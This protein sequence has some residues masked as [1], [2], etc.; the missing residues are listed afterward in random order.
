MT[1]DR[2]A[3][4][5]FAAGRTLRIAALILIVAPLVLLAV[6]SFLIWIPP[7]LIWTGVLYVIVWTT[8]FPRGRR[9]LFVTSNSPVWQP[10]LET[11]LLPHIR[12]RAVLLNWSE[13]KRWAICSF[14][15]VLF[16]HFAGPHQFNPAAIVFDAF[17]RARVFRFY[18]PFRDFKHGHPQGVE[19]LS[20]ELLLLL[21]ISTNATDSPHSN[22][23]Q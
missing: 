14:R 17:R 7:H 9:V 20:A 1:N 13:R 21:C 4:L 11:H 16:H 5:R 3:S 22:T 2:S 23:S 15:V 10:W 8:W 18:K 6:L 19:K 12:D